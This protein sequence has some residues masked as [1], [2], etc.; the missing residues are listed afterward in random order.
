MKSA[1][2][3][4]QI[5]SAPLLGPVFS[6]L[7]L[8]VARPVAAAPLPPPLPP[9]HVAALAAI[10]PDPPPKALTL[11][12]HFIVSDEKGHFVF[13]EVVAN[14]GGVFVGVGTNQ[15]Y[16]MAGWA[17][18]EVL[19]LM[20]FD[21]YVVDVHAAYIQAFLDNEAP[22]G[23]LAAWSAAGEAAMVAKLT[24]QG[25]DGARRAR[26]YER[27][28][29]RIED[30]LRLSARR[31]SARGVPTF[32]DD[33]EQYA[34]LRALCR[35]QRVVAVRGDLTAD[36]TMV[37]IG[38]AAKTLGLPV[39]VLYTSNA[40]RYFPYT[41]GF[42]RNILA[43]PFDERSLVLRTAGPGNKPEP[44]ADGHYRYVVQRGLDLQAELPGRHV[45]S[46]QRMFVRRQADPKVPG[47]YV[48][49]PLA[50]P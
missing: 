32:L 14:L 1:R 46:L 18:P 40:E 36:R 47:L 13:R 42:K 3:L 10:R 48:I 28:R 43:Q 8:C 29:A 16:L 6:A 44:T 19:V 34:Y 15:N 7:V 38:Q 41:A 25:P 5:V 2:A 27:T 24:A 12:E 39:R 35:G 50:K 37:D 31:Y 45:G 33:P 26:V 21:Q 22:A 23:F 9:E 20:D 11:N 17:R 4:L 30:R 49:P